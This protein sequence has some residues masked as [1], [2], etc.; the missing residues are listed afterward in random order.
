MGGG[1]GPTAKSFGK[2]QNQV[3]WEKSAP[4]LKLIKLKVANLSRYAI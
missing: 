3:M 1:G 2:F 4:K